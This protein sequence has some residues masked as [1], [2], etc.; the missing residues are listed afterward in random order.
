LLLLDRRLGLLALLAAL[1]LAFTR[2]YAGV[3]YPSDVAGGLALG[4]TIGAAV[5]FA[6][7]PAATA[8][9]DRLVRTPLRPLIAA[10]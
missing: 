3:H 2:I 1:L 8:L 4:A 7:R 5:V 6:L 9:A 10:R